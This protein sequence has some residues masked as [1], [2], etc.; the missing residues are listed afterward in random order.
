MAVALMP[1]ISQIAGV[2]SLPCHRMSDLPSPSKSP[3]ALICQLGPGLNGPTAPKATVRSSE[4][5]ARRDAARLRLRLQEFHH[6]LIEFVRMLQ[7]RIVAGLVDEHL[8]GAFDR[9]IQSIR[10]GRRRELVVRS[11][12]Q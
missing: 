3:V 8:A 11:P 10:I 5:N 4:R 9:R 6:H 1:F 12:N 7:E 2:P